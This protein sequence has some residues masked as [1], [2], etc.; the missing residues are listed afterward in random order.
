MVHYRVYLSS[1]RNVN[2]PFRNWKQEVYDEVNAQPFFKEG[3]A[4]VTFT[5]P[6]LFHSNRNP[7]VVQADTE[8][9]DIANV[10]FFCIDEVT[11]GTIMELAYSSLM[12]PDQ[13]MRYIITQSQYVAG[14]SWIKNLTRECPFGATHFGRVT[15]CTTPSEAVAAFVRDITKEAKD[16]EAVQ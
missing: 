9:I 13:Q 5:D 6:L 11:I 3:N 2:A 7:V 12:Y 16:T 10:V 8:N 15:L 14:H 1:T 4:V